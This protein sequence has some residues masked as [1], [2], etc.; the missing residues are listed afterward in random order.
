MSFSGGV[1]FPKNWEPVTLHYWIELAKRSDN[2]LDVGANTGSFS[3]IAKTANPSAKVVAFEPIEDTFRLLKTNIE[4][5]KYDIIAEQI[6]LSDK[7]GKAEI[8]IFPGEIDYMASLDP[9]RPAP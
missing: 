3:L 9:N 5:N 6:A 4:L 8:L 2:L 7:T 1:Y